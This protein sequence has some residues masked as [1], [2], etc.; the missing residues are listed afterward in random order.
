MAKQDDSLNN[1][2]PP[3]NLSADPPWIGFPNTNWGASLGPGFSI[4]LDPQVNVTRDFARPASAGQG[5]PSLMEMNQ[6]LE[7]FAEGNDGLLSELAR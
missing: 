7:E 4:T 5:R 3:V 1:T 6:L 2:H